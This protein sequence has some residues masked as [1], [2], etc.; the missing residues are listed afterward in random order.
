MKSFLKFLTPGLLTGSFFIL[1]PVQATPVAVGD[2]SFESQN[3]GNSTY[4]G[5]PGTGVLSATATFDNGN[6]YEVYDLSPSI[7]TSIL[8]PDWN[9]SGG[10]AG[11]WNLIDVDPTQ[12]PTS[13]NNRFLTAGTSD[14]PTFAFINQDQGLSTITS[15][16]AGLNL[17]IQALTTYTLTIA[18]GNSTAMGD[19]NDPASDEFI[20]FLA[21][22]NALNSALF[23]DATVNVSSA[24]NGTF[25]DFTATFTTGAT[26]TAGIFGDALAVQMGG[27]GELGGSPGPTVGAFDNVRLD[28][29]EAP[30]PSTWA[31]L[32]V[33]VG[34]M[35]FLARRRLA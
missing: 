25:T 23:P 21:N 6:Y 18:V 10:G 31:L 11:G 4:P 2:A 22:G 12:N 14:G 16:T 8:G 33:G 29:S 35:I 32:A 5:N 20:Q 27:S 13:Y 7:D 17:T 28:V 34:A 19:Y 26:D 1:T 3:N 30:E 15:T 9:V 24:P